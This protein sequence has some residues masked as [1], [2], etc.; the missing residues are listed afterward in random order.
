MKLH[1]LLIICLVSIL[2]LN[3]FSQG[4]TDNWLLGGADFLI[5][6]SSGEP[7]LITPS[8]VTGNPAGGIPPVPYHYFYYTSFC[9]SSISDSEGNLLMYSNGELIW[10]AAFDTMLNGTNLYGNFESSQCLFIPYPGF[11]NKYY[12]ITTP[13]VYPSFGVRYSEIDMSLDNGLGAVISSNNL[14]LSPACQKVSAVYHSNGKDIWL[15][16]HLWNSNAFYVYLI[17]PN[18]ISPNPVIS[19]VGTVHQEP[20]P[21]PPMYNSASAGDL[22]F[23]TNGKRLAVAIEGL[24]L[25]EIFDFDNTT[26]IVS[27]PISFSGE[28]AQNVEFSLDGTIAYLGDQNAYP[29]N[30]SSKIYQVDL[31]AGSQN[32][33]INSKLAINSDTNCSAIT[34]YSNTSSTCYLEHLLQLA[35]NGRIYSISTNSIAS[36]FLSSINSPNTPGI[37]CDFEFEVLTIP[38]TYC[39][40][41]LQSIPN[42]FRSYLDK[43]ILFD[44]L[45]FGDT[46]LICTQTNTNFDSIRWVFEDTL[47]GLSFSI[48]NQD[49]VFHSFSEPGSY[50]IMLKRYRNAQLDEVKKMLYI[51]PTVNIAFSDTLVCPNDTIEVFA[52]EN[53]CQFDWLNDFSTDTL[54]ADTIKINQ[55]GTYW[56]II[57][58]YDEY[59]G[60]LD[61]IT[62]DYVEINPVLGNDTSGNCITNPYILQVN[63]QNGDSVFWS[64]GETDDS[65]IAYFAGEYQATIYYEGCYDIDT[66]IVEYENLLSPDLGP[67]SFLCTG[68]SLSLSGG[69]FP[70]TNYI[71]LPTG[72]TSEQINVNNSGE[73]ILSISNICGDFSDTILVSDLEPPVVELGNDT[74]IC[75]GDTIVLDATNPQ[76]TYSWMDIFYDS[77]LTVSIAN[78]YWVIVENQCGIATDSISIFMDFP[79]EI[80]LGNDTIICQGDSLQ[81]S[82]FNYQLSIVNWSTGETTPEIFI[83]DSGIYWINL[84]N[85]CGVFSDTI[86]LLVSDPQ[87]SFPDDTLGMYSGYIE[88][89]ADSGWTA[90]FWEN[91][92]TTNQTVVSDT[93]WFSLQ[94]SDSLGCTTSDSV[95]IIDVSAIP[96]YENSKIRIFP[97]PANDELF[98][99]NIPEKSEIFVYSLLGQSMPT[100]CKEEFGNAKVLNISHLHSGGYVIGIRESGKSVG[101][102][103]FIKE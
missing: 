97:N 73:F 42:F 82:I 37:L 6:F 20:F 25:F 4:E 41:I 30:N 84:E 64:N 38:S 100:K 50:Q 2:P 85:A 29:S 67:D 32:Q 90:Y 96:E 48:A 69:T 24:N 17:T 75:S 7:S 8:V 35:P 54:F 99:T 55:P 93:G 61:T 62:V 43:N 9:G 46:T 22:K 1:S 34:N 15:M 27:N 31:L 13:Y 76:S 71:W 47:A 83:S 39:G 28:L 51:M 10:N 78:N 98:V 60:S 36:D 66:I 92:E 95:F 72:E 94:V 19:N 16:V 58:N 87:F 52:N 86:E 21:P 68:D 103:L 11:K 57:T 44:N 5:N 70:N 53:Y 81:L 91:G 102:L 56:P 23:S 26:G 33:I 77:A 74:T 49:T 40:N 14:L 12:F 101:K 3:I 79:L 89:S 18:G 63:Y 88:L 45:C 65:I 80:N 59:C